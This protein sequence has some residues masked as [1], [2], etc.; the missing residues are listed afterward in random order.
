[1]CMATNDGENSEKRWLVL[2]FLLCFYYLLEH[3]NLSFIRLVNYDMLKCRTVI[4]CR[5]CSKHY[6][7]YERIFFD[8]IWLIF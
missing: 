4:Y 6:K 1:M 5:F 7:L 2:Y 8:N 3:Q